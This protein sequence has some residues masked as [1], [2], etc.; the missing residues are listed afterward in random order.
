[1]LVYT[2]HLAVTVFKNDCDGDIDGI[3]YWSLRYLEL[4]PLALGTGRN[5]CGI[6]RKIFK[7]LEH[8]DYQ[9]FDS[10]FSQYFPVIF[11]LN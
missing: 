1:M 8:G 4:K 6:P 7:D 3:G 9:F 10:D 5:Y 11:H 2:S